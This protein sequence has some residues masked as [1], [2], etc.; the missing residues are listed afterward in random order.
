MIPI[1][2]GL[3]S[4]ALLTILKN[5]KTREVVKMRA[6]CKL[7]SKL[8]DENRTFWRDSELQES[9]QEDIEAAVN[10]FDEKSGSTLEEIRI[11]LKEGRKGS[12]LGKNHWNN[13][14][15]PRD[16]SD[17][18]NLVERPVCGFLWS[19]SNLHRLTTSKSSQ[20]GRIPSF[21]QAYKG[22]TS[23]NQLDLEVSK[24]SS[25]LASF[26]SIVLVRGSPFYSAKPLQFSHLSQSAR[27]C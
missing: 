12:R 6:I 1:N 25:T 3:P 10:Q 22:S 13:S 4:E 18:S 15:V 19:S 14:K 11:V 23:T 5:L 17:C 7:W 24:P 9:N 20:S 27:R 16:P 26:S 2:D 8:V 21:W